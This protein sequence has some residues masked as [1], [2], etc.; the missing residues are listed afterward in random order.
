MGYAGSYLLA[1]AYLSRAVLEVSGPEN[2]RVSYVIQLR[3]QAISRESVGRMVLGPKWLTYPPKTLDQIL[4]QIHVQMQSP[5]AGKKTAVLVSSAHTDPQWAQHGVE[6]LVTRF[7]QVNHAEKSPA[8]AVTV[9]DPPTKPTRPVSPNRA[10]L[11]VF[12]FGG[13]FLIAALVWTSRRLH[14]VTPK[15]A[16]MH[17]Q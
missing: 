7:L 17:L 16:T 2:D 8:Y 4:A 13:G 10:R 14:N 11:A 9:L 6:A 3:D 1:P 15:P 5:Q 12:G